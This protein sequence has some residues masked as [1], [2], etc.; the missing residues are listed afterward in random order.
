MS[1]SLGPR[2]LNN[3]L[4]L[5]RTGGASM[6]YRGTDCCERG[7]RKGV[8]VDDVCEGGDFVAVE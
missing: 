5:F 7:D 3:A 4:Q 6:R 1:F 2:I 8:H